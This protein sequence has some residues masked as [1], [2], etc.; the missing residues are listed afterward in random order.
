MIY[1]GTPKK[2][3]WAGNSILGSGKSWQK[4]KGRRASYIKGNYKEFGENNLKGNTEKKK[5]PV[6]I[7]RSTEL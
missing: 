2:T 6:K 5:K 3:R 4:L 1:C 7:N